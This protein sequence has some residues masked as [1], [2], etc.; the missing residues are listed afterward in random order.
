MPS[1][2]RQL[3]GRS[4]VGEPQVVGRLENWTQRSPRPALFGLG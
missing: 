3:K 1:V 2:L 4:E